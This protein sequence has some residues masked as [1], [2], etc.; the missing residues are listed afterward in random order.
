M[1]SL[2]DWAAGV[3]SG[4]YKYVPKSEPIPESN[5]GPVK[6]LV[7]KNWDEIVNDA[8]K[9]VFVEFYAP[10]CGH[11]KTLAPKYE[12]LGERFANSNDVIIAKIDGTANDVE[13][14]VEVRGF[15]TL[16][17]YTKDGKT[18]PISYN[19]DRDADAME[20]WINANKK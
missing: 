5:N 3:K 10:W 6:V 18:A 15:P 16:V 8:T 7:G 19:G 17:L 12:V 11:C 14:H 13:S 9:N 4:K 1:E 20:K 2:R